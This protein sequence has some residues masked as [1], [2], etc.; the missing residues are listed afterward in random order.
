MSLPRRRI[1]IRLLLA[2]SVFLIPLPQSA[3][4]QNWTIS[5]LLCSQTSS[6]FGST[7]VS[8]SFGKTEFQDTITFTA[9]ADCSTPCEINHL[10]RSVTLNIGVTGTCQYAVNYTFTGSIQQASV[11]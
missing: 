5:G 8:C 9:V 6:N 11:P 2:A 10:S 1:L 4:A 7:Q 3:K